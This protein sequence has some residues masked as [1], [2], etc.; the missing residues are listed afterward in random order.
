MK[1]SDSVSSSRRKSRKVC[2]ALREEEEE[3]MITTHH[4]AVLACCM[5]CRLFFLLGAPVSPTPPASPPSLQAHFSAPSNVRH[6]LM[7]APLSTELRNK[8]S[9]SL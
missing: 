4:D 5:R 3:R 2:G 8:Y 7:S 1:F 6:K 9:V